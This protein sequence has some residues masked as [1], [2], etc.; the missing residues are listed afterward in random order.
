MIQ[1]EKVEQD[2]TYCDICGKAAPCYTGKVALYVTKYTTRDDNDSQAAFLHNVK[3]DI[4]RECIFKALHK[5][6]SSGIFSANSDVINFLSCIKS[7][8]IERLKQIRNN[9]EEDDSNA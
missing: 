3:F 1:R 7:A 8:V 6:V 9:S 2:V 5:K 4:C